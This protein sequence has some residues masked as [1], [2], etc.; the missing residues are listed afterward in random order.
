MG[1]LFSTL[2]EN[3]FPKVCEF[4][5]TFPEVIQENIQTALQEGKT[6]APLSEQMQMN[7]QEKVRLSI[8][9]SLTFS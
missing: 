6:A 8:R 1:K 2:C 3:Y 5:L 7:I 4:Y 9:E